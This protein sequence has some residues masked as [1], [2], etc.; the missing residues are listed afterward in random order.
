VRHE[1][2]NEE[3]NLDPNKMSEQIGDYDLILA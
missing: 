2:G 1:E 3:M